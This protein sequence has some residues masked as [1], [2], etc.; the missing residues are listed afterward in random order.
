MTSH[1]NPSAKLEAS[2]EKEGESLSAKR[3]RGKQKHLI[4]GDK[5]TV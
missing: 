1:L 3:G 5:K 2:L 4:F